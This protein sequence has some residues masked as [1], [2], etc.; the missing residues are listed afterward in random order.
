MKFEMLLRDADYLIDA[1]AQEPQQR[2]KE[3]LVVGI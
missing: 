3:V 2:E 1:L